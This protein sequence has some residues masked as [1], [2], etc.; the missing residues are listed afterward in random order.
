MAQDRRRLAGFGHDPSSASAALRPKA[1]EEP[2]DGPPDVPF[3]LTSFKVSRM[4]RGALQ[5]QDGKGKQGLVE[6]AE[7][8]LKGL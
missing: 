2:T 3:D 7:G 4:H 6:K 5:G 1:S 8:L